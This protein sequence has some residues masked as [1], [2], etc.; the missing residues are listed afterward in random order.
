MLLSQYGR[1][2]ALLAFAAVS[3]LLNA[4][5]STPRERQAAARGGLQ[6]L[7]TVAR[8]AGSSLR[9]VARTAGRLDSLNRARKSQPLQ[10]AKQAAADKYL[11]GAFN[12]QLGT[13]TA[14]SIPDAYA[15]LLRQTRASRRQWTARD[16]DYAADTYKRLNDELTRVRLDLPARDELRI[17]AWQAEF[18]ALQANRTVKDLR[19]LTTPPSPAASR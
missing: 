6:E 16:W 15:Q 4:C 18:K 13:L 17:R 5:D 9:R 19:T 11:L 8:E 14:A 2:P 3:M 12:G 1:V 7:D 10:S